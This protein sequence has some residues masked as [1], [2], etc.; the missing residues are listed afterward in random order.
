MTY[1]VQNT[2]GSKTINVAASQVNSAF[3]IALVGR[4]VS[5]YGQYFVQN[6]I[7]H[8]ENFASTSAP[9]DDQLLEGQIWY[10]K[11]EEIIRVY[12]GASW[13]RASIT[14]SATAPTDGVE[15]GTAYYDTVDD[16]LKVHDGTQFV[17][18]SYAGKVS[19]EFSN[20][21]NL[22]SP[23][24]YGTRLRTIYLVDDTGVH[25]A[26]LGLMYVSDGSDAGYTDGESVMAVF[27][28]HAQFDISTTAPAK[29]EGLGDVNLYNQF[30]D[31]DG[32]GT[33]IRPGMNLRNKY[34]GTAVSL[35]NSSIYAD[36]AN[37]ISTASGNVIGSKVYTAAS[38]ALIPDDTDSV[39][40]GNTANRY[41][42][43]YINDISIGNPTSSSARYIK[44]SSAT[45]LLDIGEQSAPVDNLHVAN[46]IIK[47]GGGIT[48]LNID[49]YGSNTALIDEIWASEVYL[50][51]TGNV[52][53]DASGVYGLPI[54]D[55]SGTLLVDPSAGQAATL[56][57]NNPFT[58]ENSF[59]G[60]ISSVGGKDIG[61]SSNRFGT[62]FAG[63]VDATVGDISGDLDVGGTVTAPLFDGVASSA[64]YADLAEKYTADADYEA[65]TV[66][67]IG[68]DAEVTQTT[69]HNDLD[70]FGV[71]SSQPA[72]LMNSELDGVAIAMTGRVPVRV[73]GKVKK[74]ERLISSSVP[75]VAWAMSDEEYDPRAVIGRSLDDKDD[76][77][78]G[79]VEAVI[80]V[81]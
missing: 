59:S 81:K 56:G 30:N 72:Y 55:A 3:S 10:D 57:G 40:M 4:N 62:V 78:I 50:D 8:L 51:G 33:T 43:L 73:V 37:A 26:V 38:T 7:R 63:T 29:V 60:N 36:V 32:I 14:V 70:V 13:R 45:V 22:G 12:D 44:K 6:A 2:D 71:V 39:P 34:A 11:G 24:K 25:R 61:T 68:G 35:A 74:G 19:N 58:G 53:V 48:G 23:S 31:S 20:D 28:D 46:I 9:S 69:D 77:D 41:S 1:S 21:V 17:D 49:T 65:G 66:V 79:T 16:K 27:S 80:G 15:S 18:S 5:G 67:K 42:E 47:D 52:K 64:K 54:Y 76:G 75:G